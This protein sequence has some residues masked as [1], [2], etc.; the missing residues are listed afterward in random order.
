[1]ATGSTSDVKLAS[2]ALIRL[3]HTT[4]ASFTDGTAG[5]EVM[6]NLF[7]DSYKALLTQTR[8]RFATRTQRLSKLTTNP[9]NTSY[10]YQYTLP[11]DMLYVI[12]A[13]SGSFNK[14]T[15]TFQTGSSISNYEIYGDKLYAN[16]SDLAIDYISNIPSNLIPS[17]FAI[18][19][20]FYLASIAA[21]AITGDTDK[22][23]YFDKQYQK[24][25]L[26]AKFA[27]SSQ[28]PSDS[29]A[30]QSPYISVRG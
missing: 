17:Y 29:L 28:R 14:N 18:T 6:S 26:R 23:D 7:E 2:N 1:M 16:E 30:D 10:Q 19:V 8:W 9:D 25:L 22:A 24:S 3:G 27:D 21:I 11:S 20:E 15:N 12:K 5:A 4:I 13:S